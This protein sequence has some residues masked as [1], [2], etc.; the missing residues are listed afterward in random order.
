MYYFIPKNIYQKIVSQ[1]NLVTNLVTILT[2]ISFSCFSNQ[3]VGNTE[4]DLNSAV[5]SSAVLPSCLL[6]RHVD[7]NKPSCS[8]AN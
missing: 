7:S 6:Q 8:P 2:T 1:H 3:A 5:W 4:A